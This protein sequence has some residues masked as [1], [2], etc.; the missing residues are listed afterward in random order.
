MS[1]AFGL[2]DAV[3]HYVPERARSFGIKPGM[4]V[5]D[6]GCGPGRFTVEFAQLV[7]PDGHVYAVDLLP[8]ALEATK[9]RLDKA[10]LTGVELL[11]ADDYN[12]GV[13]TSAAD[14]V[15]AIDMFH[16]VEPIPF[17]AEAA[18]I[19]KPDGVLIFSGGHMARPQ[20]K[21]EITASPLWRLDS[22]TPEYLKYVKT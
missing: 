6:Y 7:G 17:L 9:R 15:C 16:H 14:M 11:L 3:H 20:L 4:T 1:A 12:S 8:I 2:V 5:V 13:P 10:G 19:T 21:D 22:D 18:R